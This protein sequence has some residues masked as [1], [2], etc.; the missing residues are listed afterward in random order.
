[1]TFSWRRAKSD[2]ISSVAWAIAITA[3]VYGYLPAFAAEPQSSP[4]VAADI[5]PANS[6]TWSN[7]T[8]FPLNQSQLSELLSSVGPGAK[9]PATNRPDIA[10]GSQTIISTSFRLAFKT[11]HQIGSATIEFDSVE[12]AAVTVG[13]L[14]A[15]ALYPGDPNKPADWDAVATT[16]NHGRFDCIFSPGS[17]PR[18]LLCTVTKAGAPPTLRRWHFDER[19]LHNITPY[20]LAQGEQA[21][22]G[23]PPA[24]IVSG[25]AWQNAGMDR[26][27][28]VERHP[29]TDIEPS[30]LI[31]NWPTAQSPALVR[32]QGNVGVFKLLAFTGSSTENPALA[33]EDR[34]KNLPFTELGREPAGDGQES[35]LIALR[36]N[37]T[38]AIKLEIEEPRPKGSQIVS[39]SEFSVWTDLKDQP[40]PPPPSREEHPPITIEYEVPQDCEMAMVVDDD[41]GHRIRNLFAQEERKAG[42]HVAYWDL[43]DEDGLLA[44]PGIYHWRAI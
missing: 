22:L 3:L 11:P 39:V 34:W 24:N 5:D 2:F 36:G 43:T 28:K 13:V 40:V 27:K 21:P 19:R 8:S 12:G 44:P 4:I 7:G 30:W 38:R 15:N 32:L 42:K 6:A 1:M 9:W 23:S 31:L 16:G 33:N 41:K 25:G 14:K 29:I 18:A 37:L 35:I 20:A 10:G 26:E 17:S